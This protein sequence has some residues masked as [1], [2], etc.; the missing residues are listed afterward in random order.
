MMWE[1]PGGKVDF[2]ET[3]EQALVR[4][5]QE[6][7][8]Y[9]VDIARLLPFSHATDWA[10]E[11]FRQHTVIYCYEGTVRERPKEEGPKDHKIEVLKWFTF[12]EID[13][14]RV[15]RGSREFIWHV[16]REHSVELT[17]YVPQTAYASFTCIEPK[18]G[19]EKFYSIVLQ[20]NPGSEEYPYRLVTRWGRLDTIPTRNLNIEAFSSDDKIRHRVLYHLRRRRSHGYTLTTYSDNFPL[21]SFLETFRQGRTTA[22]EQ[23]PLWQSACDFPNVDKGDPDRS[24]AA[25]W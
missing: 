3:G 4:E 5:V 16:A 18:E 10:Y 21:R 22:D 9:G 13:F 25:L 20:I 17:G 8:G 1:L 12:D 6:E 14:S 7:T 2:G 23:L 11:G 19:K 15:L 24:S